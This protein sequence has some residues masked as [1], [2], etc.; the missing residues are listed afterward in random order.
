MFWKIV[1]LALLVWAV[2]F[3]YFSVSLGGMIHLIPIAAVVLAV[4]RRMA[5]EPNTEF[6]RWRS[7][8][9]RDRR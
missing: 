6:G 2:A 8:A 9:D 3:F 4:V 5:K 7:S 1:V